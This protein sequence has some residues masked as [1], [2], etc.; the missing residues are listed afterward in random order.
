M[1]RTATANN[2]L[3][4]YAQK[5][6]LDLALLQEPYA[7][8]GR[9]TGLETAPFR[10]IISPGTKQEGGHNILHGAAI[11]IFN[12]ALTV[13]ARNDLTC[14]NFAVATIKLGDE[15]DINLISAYFK[16]RK[17]TSEMLE[18]LQRLKQKCGH[19]TIIGGDINAFST[20]WGSKKT[21]NKGKLVE[22]FID[23]EQLV[24]INK[25]NHTRFLDREGRTTLT[26]H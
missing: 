3:L 22:E 16:F 13:L 21:N 25:D 15:E 23:N 9:I 17:P 24:L 1:A 14:E 6:G 19:R 10:I 5:E 7:R 8:Y 12:P 4:E 11:V 2:D 20:R 18:T 26:S